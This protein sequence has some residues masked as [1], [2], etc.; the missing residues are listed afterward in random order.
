[1]VEQLTRLRSRGEAART[2]K[3]SHLAGHLL[4]FGRVHDEESHV[5]RL[6]VVTAPID[7]CDLGLVHVRWA[8]QQLALASSL[9]GWVAARVT[10]DKRLI[11]PGP[12]DLARAQARLVALGQDWRTGASECG[13]A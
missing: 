3:L 1:V 2:V 6:V 7:Q 11:A 8:G 9:S 4:A 5:A 13:A 10:R 12:D